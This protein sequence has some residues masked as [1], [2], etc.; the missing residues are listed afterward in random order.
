MPE[1]NTRSPGPSVTPS[2]HLSL[3]HILSGGASEEYDNR[4]EKGSGVSMVG[5]ACVPLLLGDTTWGLL[6]FLHFGLHRW[7]PEEIS[8]LQAIASMLVQL[9]G[10]L[11]AD[12]RT[13]YN[14]CLLYTS[15]CV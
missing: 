7:T 12:E 1:H 9:Q 13:E 10:R 8:A 3:I 4:I 14:A 5:G 6:G 2:Q 15:R 11:D